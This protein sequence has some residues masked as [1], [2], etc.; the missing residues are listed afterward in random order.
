MKNSKIFFAVIAAIVAAICLCALI[1]PKRADLPPSKPTTAATETF[2]QNQPDP[3]T[4]SEDTSPAMPTVTIETLPTYELAGNVRITQVE[5][6][7]NEIIHAF[8]PI[9]K[10]DP[11]YL[12][13]GSDAYETMEGKVFRNDK[14]ISIDIFDEFLEKTYTFTFGYI[15]GQCNRF[16]Y[17]NPVCEQA[18]RRNQ[19]GFHFSTLQPGGGCIDT[20]PATFDTEAATKKAFRDAPNFT[21]E[22]TLD[23]RE[24]SRYED[25]THPGTV[26]F[27]QTPLQ[28]DLWIDVMVYQMGG[29]FVATL[30]L[31]IAKGD[32]GTYSIVNLQNKNL[33][34]L[35]DQED[36]MISEKE[37]GYIYSLA[38]EIINDPEAIKF[39]NNSL[40]QDMPI[41]RYLIEY[42]DESTS[43]YFPYFVPAGDGYCVKSSEYLY[44][45][46]IAVTARQHCG[47]ATCVTMYFHVIKPA[48][49]SDHGVYEY[50]GRDFLFYTDKQ[51]LI[52][53]GHPDF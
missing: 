6:D 14:T 13:S 1:L 18:E 49:D 50:I 42:R 34:Q 16:L 51:A 38:D 8:E 45:P 20:I 44:N 15:T 25:P 41:E 48:T 52:N 27:T 4:G 26:W 3:D 10:D 39:A 22:R 5:K 23:E 17:L 47:M 9:G 21:V 33:L 43:L 35:Y 24:I 37:L 11:E 46:I 12:S 29:D 2:S 32:D 40:M 53:Q 36:T 28:D 30:R 31:T 7:P 19:F